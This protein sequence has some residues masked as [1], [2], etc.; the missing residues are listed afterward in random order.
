MTH[1]WSS[2]RKHQLSSPC[3]KQNNLALIL[4]ELDMS[5]IYMK[6]KYSSL[7][8][9][10]HG[11]A[12]DPE[13]NSTS[14]SWWGKVMPPVVSSCHLITLQSV[15]MW[16]NRTDKIIIVCDVNGQ[17]IIS[18]EEAQPPD[19]TR[20]DWTF[21]QSWLNAC[22]RTVWSFVHGSFNWWSYF[23]QECSHIKPKAPERDIPSWHLLCFTSKV[24]NSKRCVPC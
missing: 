18:H 19:S 22:D 13:D 10:D 5:H 16:Y 20:M 14:S 6:S 17:K 23:V 1:K 7:L 21:Q 11:T 9:I 8:W 15:K 24:R 12:A 2:I 3:H 4:G